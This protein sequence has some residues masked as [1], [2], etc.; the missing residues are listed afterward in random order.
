[1]RLQPSTAHDPR[2]D[3]P[4]GPPVRWAPLLAAL[5]Q[6]DAEQLAALAAVRY[7]RQAIP[8]E[9][10]PAQLSGDHYRTVVDF[11]AD[12]SLVR[13]LVWAS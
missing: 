11:Q 12:G 13:K 7:E 10:W 3:H 1:M 2:L 6:R 9:H 5:A 4:A 8:G